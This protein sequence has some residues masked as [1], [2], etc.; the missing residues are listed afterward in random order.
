MKTEWIIDPHASCEIISPKDGEPSYLATRIA[1]AYGDT[2]EERTERARLIAAAPD[3][4]EA[5]KSAMDAIDRACRNDTRAIQGETK[6]KSDARAA[7]AKVG[8]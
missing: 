7:L 5:L 2:K 6:W 4:Y 3:L 1:Q 8:E